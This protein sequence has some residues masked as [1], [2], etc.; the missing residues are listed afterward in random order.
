V[1]KPIIFNTEMVTAIIQGR[2]TE[3]R[4]VVKGFK[5]CEIGDILY[6]R[7]T[8]G[9]TN[10]LGDFARKNQTAEY[11]YKAGYAKGK[12][13]SITLKDHKNLGKWKP[14]IHMPKDAARIF[15][16]VVNIRC[17]KLHE[18]D[19]KGVKKEGLE[20]GYDGWLKSFKYL[21]NGIYNN[22]DEN[23]FVWV[24]EFERIYK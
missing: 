2:K 8:W 22:W 16:K 15:L 4:R 21:W 19:Y 13:I 6:V 17:D 11:M 20:V 3:T 7:E 12:R 1:E 10:P 5:P 24:I 23:P 18:I 14:S 9:I